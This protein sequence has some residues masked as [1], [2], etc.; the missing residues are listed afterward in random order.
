[1]PPSV[2]GIST[3]SP[4]RLSVMVIDSA[5][6]H[7]VAVETSVGADATAPSSLRAH[8]AAG[9]RPGRLSVGERDLAGHERRPVPIDLLHQAT[10]SGGEVEDHLRLMQAQALEI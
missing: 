3:A 2:S 4:V 10:A 6:A 5:M 9:S 1:M 7:L 8:Q